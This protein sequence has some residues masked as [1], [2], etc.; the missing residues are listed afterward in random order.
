MDEAMKETKQWA[1]VGLGRIGSSLEMDEQ[2]EKPCTHAGAI[3]ATKGVCLAG[4]CDTNREARELFSRQW[5]ELDPAPLLFSD[6]E[7]MLEK[8]RPDL[9][10]IATPPDT[11]L[12]LVRLALSAGVPVVVC[13]KP[14]AWTL[15]QAST[16]RS[17]ARRSKSRIIVNHERRFSADYR[18]VKDAIDQKLYGN[19]LSIHGTLYFGRS[20]PHKAVLI[21]DGT[22]M[23]DAVNFLCD[24]H[25]IP[26]RR[27]G[28]PKSNKGTLQLCGCAGAVAVSLDI[29]GERDHLVFRL[30]LNFERGKIEIG[31]G[32]L[33]FFKSVESPFYSGFHSLMPDITPRFRKTG[34][35]STM[36]ATAAAMVDQNGMP[37]PSS[38]E[39]GW[40]VLRAIYRI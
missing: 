31:N 24:A 15:H 3:V 35:F 6:A 12:A 9:L 28:N 4:A 19:L 21:H 13:E 14:I 22:H 23:I 33:R 7:A 38:A 20:A 16:I 39:D 11:H 26:K 18:V 2:R 32:L 10:T 1:L 8:L 27:L 17:L 37:S 40:A 29:G 34:Y 25:F 36:A 30:D 5:K